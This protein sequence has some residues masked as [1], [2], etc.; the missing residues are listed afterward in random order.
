MTR[1]PSSIELKVVS[2]ATA[3]QILIAC[4][5]NSS[6]SFSRG[7][8]YTGMALF[9]IACCAAQHLLLVFS[10]PLRFWRV[11]YIGVMNQ[12]RP[13]AMKCAMKRSKVSFSTEM[14]AGAIINGLQYLQYMLAAAGPLPQSTHSPN[15]PKTTFN[16]I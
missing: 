10:L 15:S 4:P 6:I 7:A 14:L 13:T 16:G 1:W 12:N 2:G 8:N 5:Q 11:Q 3:P 9:F